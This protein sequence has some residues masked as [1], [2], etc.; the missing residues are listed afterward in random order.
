M[1]VCGQGG[2]AGWGGLGPTAFPQG[3]SCGDNTPWLCTPIVEETDLTSCSLGVLLGRCSSVVLIDVPMPG[4]GN[5]CP[6]VS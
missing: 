1:N 2:G 3:H 4:R 6:G 5:C